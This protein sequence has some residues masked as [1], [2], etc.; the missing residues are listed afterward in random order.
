MDS[1]PCLHRFLFA[2]FSIW[3]S[4]G[5]ISSL[6]QNG[7]CLLQFFLT[8]A[9]FSIMNWYDSSTFWTSIFLFLL[10]CKCFQSILAHI[11][12]ILHKACLISFV[13]AFFKVCYQLA[14]IVGTLK[15]IGKS[16]VPDAIFYP[17]FSTVFRFPCIGIQTSR[18]RLFV[19]TVLITDHAIHSTRSEHRDINL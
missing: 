13:V 2:R 18:T 5:K 8:L 1:E 9:A 19:I 6:Q 4:P 12:T 11:F 14:W 3:W 15:T 16:A 10:L 7:S 17:A